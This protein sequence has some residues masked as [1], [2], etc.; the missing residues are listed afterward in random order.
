MLT[1]I[2]GNSF[3]IHTMDRCLNHT[4][5]S[6]NLF[7]VEQTRRALNISSKLSFR[8][9]SV[10]NLVKPQPMEKSWL[11]VSDLNS[12]CFL[13]L[14]PVNSFL[15]TAGSIASTYALHSLVF[16][17]QQLTFCAVHCLIHKRRKQSS[18][19]YILLAKHTNI[20]NR[21]NK[22][23]RTCLHASLK[24]IFDTFSYTATQYLTMCVCV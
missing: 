13:F 17:T 5:S 12:N 22:V 10:R 16:T 19:I 7:H 1:L 4:C 15:A 18:Q 9:T 24:C 20:C 14:N 8:K 23:I 11:T 2:S 21:Q 3:S 6:M